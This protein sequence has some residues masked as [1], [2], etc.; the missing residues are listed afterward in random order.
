MAFTNGEVVFSGNVASKRVDELKDICWALAGRDDGT[1]DALIAIIKT[2]LTDPA[3]QNSLKFSGLYFGRRPA[4]TD[5]NAPLPSP[6][7]H[8]DPALASTSA[9]TSAS[10][11]HP[12]PLPPPSYYHS[13]RM[14]SLSSITSTYRP[15]FPLQPSTQSRSNDNNST[16]CPSSSSVHSQQPVNDFSTIQP[17]HFYSL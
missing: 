16:I 17:S 5:E 14:P 6:A 10:A 13:A 7:L 4:A 12:P 2:R 1:K 3:I 15:Y 9:L 11:P 8:P